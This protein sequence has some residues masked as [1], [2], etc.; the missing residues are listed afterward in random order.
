MN[1]IKVRDVDS[2][3]SITMGLAKNGYYV[4]S[5]YI[6]DENYKS[7]WEI[8][9]CSN[10]VF[11]EQIKTNIDNKVEYKLEE[12]EIIIPNKDDTEIEYNKK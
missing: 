5:N 11:E 1:I 4:T 12:E 3:D 2:C 8:K 7:S 6:T 10:E 9:Y